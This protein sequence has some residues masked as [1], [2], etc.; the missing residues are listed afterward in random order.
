[1][2]SLCSSTSV[3]H[4]KGV[5]FVGG[6]RVRGGKAFRATLAHDNMSNFAMAHN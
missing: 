1:M 5:K 3:H 4:S 6:G 2:M